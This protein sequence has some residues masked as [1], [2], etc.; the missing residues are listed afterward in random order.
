MAQL[1][2][3]GRFAMSQ[4][5]QKDR[6]SDWQLLLFPFE[7]YPI[8]AFLF[9]SVFACV[10]RHYRHGYDVDGFNNV[11]GCIDI[12][13]ILCFGVLLTVALFQLLL[14]EYRSALRSIGFGVLNI[15]VCMLCLP[16]FVK[17]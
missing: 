6:P 5:V 3:L 4:F 7:V 9:Y 13:C 15:I 16:I 17:A 2:K 1:S 8:V 10:W 14:K 11:A 12:G